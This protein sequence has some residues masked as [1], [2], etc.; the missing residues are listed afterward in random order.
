MKQFKFLEVTH[1]VDGDIDPVIIDEVKYEANPDKPE[2]ALLDDKGDK[3]PFKE[4]PADKPPEEKPVDVSKMSVEDLAK[5]NPALAK[6]LEDGETAQKTLTDKEKEEKEA[7]EKKEEETG[8]WQKLAI[9][10]KTKVDSLENDNKKKD[11]LI[12]KYKGSV[13]KILESAMEQIPEENRGLIPADFSVRQKLDYINANAKVLGIKTL[14]NVGDGKTPEGD[15]TKIGTKEQQL[16][17]ELSDLMK[18]ENKTPA[19]LDSMHT[20]SKQIKEE[21]AK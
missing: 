9:E 1:C 14:V 6:A 11:E 13:N 4:T 12:I 21:R 17:K 19:E 5:I 2:E 15:E 7:K 10:R 20:L 3:V 8:D 18:K 16:V